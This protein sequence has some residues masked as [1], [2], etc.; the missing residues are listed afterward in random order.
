MTE[1]T[2]RNDPCPCGS[3]KKFKKC[4][5][6]K[7]EVIS[8]KRLIDSDL[9]DLQRELLDFADARYREDLEDDFADLCD[10]LE[11]HDPKEIEYYAFTH[12]IWFILFS[13]LDDEQTILQKFIHYKSGKL[14]RPTLKLALQSWANAFVAAGVVEEIEGNH[15]LLSDTLRKKKF[16]IHSHF[17]LSELNKGTYVLGMVLPFQ[18]NFSFFPGPYPFGRLEAS[19]CMNYVKDQFEYSSQAYE[20][21]DEFLAEEFLE[22]LD[23][24]PHLGGDGI[25]ESFDWPLPIHQDVADLFIEKMEEMNQMPKLVAIGLALWHRYCQLDPKNL[26]KPNLYAAAVQYFVGAIMADEALF[27]QK[28]LAGEF[29]VAVGSISAKFNE[30]Y[31]VLEP[32]LD[33][34]V[35]PFFEKAAIEPSVPNIGFT[36]NVPASVSHVTEQALQDVMSQIQG[37]EFESMEEANEFLQTFLQQPEKTKS[38]KPKSKKGQAQD[39]IY[40]AFEAS[41]KKRFDLARQAL[42]LDPNMADAYNILAEEVEQPILRLDFYEKAMKIAEKELGDKKFF[43]ENKGYFWGLLET[44]PYMRAKA[45]YALTVQSQGYDMIAIKHF[46]EMLDLNPMDNQGVRYPLFISYLKEK[47][48]GKAR[49]LLKRYPEETTEGLYNELLLELL[50]NGFTPKASNLLKEALKTNRFVIDYVTGEKKLP[51]ATIQEYYSFGSKEEAVGYAENYLELW[52]EVSGLKEWVKVGSKK[53]K[54]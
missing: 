39:L 8:I 53:S 49:E 46:K 37:K 2:G 45:N 31:N 36:K 15:L 16:K 50:E 10:I 43:K 51:A 22:L 11:L 20:T 13:P 24:M 14:K 9:A 41:G 29:E 12:T 27:T 3:G 19:D 6:S 1:K 28:Q 52:K 18:D 4:C 54:R 44:R 26:K 42:E 25:T 32:E 21:V 47:I 48:F 17:E 33:A 30:M 40:Q 5:E 35:M 7:G 34:V 38:S 23:M